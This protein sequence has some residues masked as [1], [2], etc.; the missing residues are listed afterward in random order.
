MEGPA[1][2]VGQNEQCQIADRAVRL[3]NLK[4]STKP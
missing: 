4:R 2:I 1:M 3:F